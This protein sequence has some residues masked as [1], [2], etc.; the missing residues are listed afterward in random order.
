MTLGCHGCFNWQM[1]G[2]LIWIGA[3]LVAWLVHFNARDQSISMVESLGFSGSRP[4][5]LRTGL[6]ATIAMPIMGLATIV[7]PHVSRM[8]S[9]IWLINLQSFT[10]VDP[11]VSVGCLSWLRFHPPGSRGGHELCGFLFTGGES[12]ERVDC[13]GV[14]Y[15]KGLITCSRPLTFGSERWQRRLPNKL[16]MSCRVGK[17]YN[18][19][20][21]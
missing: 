12:L 13:G 15:C 21:V 9:G 14:M 3:N 19:C 8:G 2:K 18:L 17:V 10:A 6:W 11:H 16:E 7:Q 20:R 4:S 5:Q 1:K